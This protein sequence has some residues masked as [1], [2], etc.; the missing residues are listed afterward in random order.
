MRA[1]VD[2]EEYQERVRCHLLAVILWHIH[3]GVDVDSAAYF[4]RVR[5]AYGSRVVDFIWSV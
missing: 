4:W 5:G 1:S 2:S 3:V